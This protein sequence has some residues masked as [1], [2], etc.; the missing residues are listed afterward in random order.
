MRDNAEIFRDADC[1]EVIERIRTSGNNFE[2]LEKYLIEIL[3][4]LDPQGKGWVSS[5][6][7]LEG[8]KKFNLYLSTQEL[9]TLVSELTR[10]KDG[11][12]SMED[13]YNLIV[14]YK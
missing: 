12:Y 4:A 10:N 5:D 2:S 1:S 6:T 7:I 8:F 11:D 3:R 9:I 14:C 13:L